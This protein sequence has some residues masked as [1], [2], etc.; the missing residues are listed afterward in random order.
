MYRSIL[1]LTGA[2]V[3][4]DSGVPTFRDSMGLWEHHRVEEVASPEGFAVNPS[5]VHRF[6]N[7][8]RR[9]LQEGIEPNPAHFAIA[10]LERDYPGSVWVVT[11]NIDDL[12]ERGGQE[13]VIHMHGELL[14]AFCLNCGGVF[15]CRGDLST[16][17]LCTTCQTKGSLRPRVVWFGEMPLQMPMIEKLIEQTDLFIAIGTSG[18]V[19]PAAGFVQMA[20]EAGAETL[21]MNIETTDNF[22][23]DRAI[24]GKASEVV[25]V[26]VN[27]LLSE[28]K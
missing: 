23:F 7:E 12:H 6:Y 14:K 24:Q 10:Q 22:Y 19:Y 2:G 28:G 20:K 11:Q 16:E 25:P 17:S 21:E 4:A 27:T 9:K 18:V 3:S 5:L 15:E 13:N 8:R 26:F 1:I